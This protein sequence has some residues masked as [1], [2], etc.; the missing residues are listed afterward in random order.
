MGNVK[1]HVITEK[2][3]GCGACV[4]HCPTGAILLYTDKTNRKVIVIRTETCIGCGECIPFCRY[5]ALIFK[6]E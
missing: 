5:G 2:C 4:T 1:V 3:K 6:G